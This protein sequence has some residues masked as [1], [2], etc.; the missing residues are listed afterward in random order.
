MSAREFR[1]VAG[2]TRLRHFLGDIELVEKALRDDAIAAFWLRFAAAHGPLAD[3]QTMN[4]LS[5]DHVRQH[6][7]GRILP[8]SFGFSIGLGRNVFE[9]DGFRR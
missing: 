6:V 9:P 7:G 1:P 5:F 3:V 2:C 8:F 4:R